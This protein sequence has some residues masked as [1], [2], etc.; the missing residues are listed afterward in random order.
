MDDEE[1]A[2]EERQRLEYREWLESQRER[3]SDEAK[4]WD[5]WLKNFKDKPKDA[6]KDYFDWKYEGEKGSG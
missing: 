3:E 5:E 4:L 1:W 2:E 6:K